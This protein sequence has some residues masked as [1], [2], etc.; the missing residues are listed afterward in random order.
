MAKIN[1]T[2]EMLNEQST[3]LRQYKTEHEQVY[4]QIRQLVGDITSVWEGESQQA[5]QASFAGKENVFKQ[6][7]DEIEQFAQL[8]N[9]AARQMQ[10]TEA[11]ITSQMRR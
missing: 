11:Q 3:K 9:D 8:M 5:F 6:F 7:A 10:D 1:I 2:P 4:T